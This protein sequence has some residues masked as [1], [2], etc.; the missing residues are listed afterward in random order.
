MIRDFGYIADLL[1]ERM[2]CFLFQLPPSFDYS[3]ARLRRILDQLD[4]QRRNVIEFRHASWWRRDVYRAFEKTGAIFCACSGP[5]LPDDVVCTADDLYVRFHGTQR[6][7]RHDYSDTE[8]ADWARRIKAAGAK[9][10]WAYFNNDFQAF[11]I[12]N[13]LTLNH[14]LT[15]SGGRLRRAA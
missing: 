11:A 4:P 9:R 13:A 12:K 6:W 7:Y 1:G 8:L 3:P 5:K 14:M 15:A 10:V 2:G